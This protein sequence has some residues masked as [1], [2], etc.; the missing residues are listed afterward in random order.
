[1]ADVADLR[2]RLQSIAEELADAG[3]DVLREAVAAGATKR[4]DAERQLVKARRAVEKAIVELDRLV[5]AA[6]GDAGDGG[7]DDGS[8]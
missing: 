3:I 1:M 7:G 5:A 8:V 4:P 2:E 6:D